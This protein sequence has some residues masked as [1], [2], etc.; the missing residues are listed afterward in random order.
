MSNEMTIQEMKN[1]RHGLEERIRNFITAAVNEFNH[2]LPP[3]ASVTDVRVSLADT[4]T[5]DGVTASITRD[6]RVV[7]AELEVTIAR[8]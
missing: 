4:S 7:D 3:C 1:A 2:E 6:S 8:D 5:I